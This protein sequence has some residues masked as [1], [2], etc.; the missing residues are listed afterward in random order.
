MHTRERIA[1]FILDPVVLVSLTG[2]LFYTFGISAIYFLIS[3]LI[4]TT[5]HSVLAFIKL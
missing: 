4:L 2:I 3:S 5:L 1:R